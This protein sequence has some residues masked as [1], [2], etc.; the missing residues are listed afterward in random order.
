EYREEK[1]IV[2]ISDTPKILQSFIS[3]DDAPFIFEKTGNRFKHF[4]ID[5]F[6]DTS[7]LQW[8][9]LLP[10][11]SNSLAS[12]HFTMVVGDAKQSI[13]RWRGGNMNLLA[14]EVRNAFSHYDSIITEENLA[15]N[16]RSKRNI[17]E[18]NNA[19]F[20]EVPPLIHR[21]LEIGEDS[22]LHL[23]Y[24]GELKQLVSGKHDSGGYVQVQFFED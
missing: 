11:I 10:L 18:F 1:N 23:V 16:Y 14:R 15:T 17:I 6:Q 21:E 24:S 3:A 19:F 20:T 8:M 7:S 5:E 2:L 12:G 22:L 4:L 13:Y 9:N